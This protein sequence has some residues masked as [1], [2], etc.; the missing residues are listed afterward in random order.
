M[1][2]NKD[3]RN[4]HAHVSQHSLEIESAH[5]RQ[6][7]VQDQATR[8]TG[9]LLVQKLLA[10]RKGLCTQTNGLDEIL[11]S[12]AHATIVVDDKPGGNGRWFHT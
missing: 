1:C 7:Y 4:L 3:D 9:P 8:V 11:Y 6:P 2:R 12:P 5:L 10:S